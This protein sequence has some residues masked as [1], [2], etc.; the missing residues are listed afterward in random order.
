MDEIIIYNVL[1]TVNPKA[2]NSEV[3]F[4]CSAHHIMV[5]YICMQFQENISNSFQVTERTHILQK[6]L[7][8]NVRRAIT[9]KVG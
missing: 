5:R 6:S 8:F 2:G 7:I 1:R 3:W 9:P 4:V